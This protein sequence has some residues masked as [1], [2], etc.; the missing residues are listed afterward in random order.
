MSNAAG[1]LG[2]TVKA[3]R[4]MVPAKDYEIRKRFYDGP[5]WVIL[6]SACPRSFS[7][8]SG[9]CLRRDYPCARSA[10]CC[11]SG[12]AAY[13]SARLLRALALARRRPANASGRA[14]RAGLIW[15]LA[16]SLDDETLERR[17]YPAPASTAKD[18]RGPTGR[19]SIAS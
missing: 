2:E 15:P 18:K 12:P 14:R 19:R 7:T 1:N 6:E 13:P 9:T 5:R 16:A 3:M 17:L 4:P 8:R 11:G 10:M